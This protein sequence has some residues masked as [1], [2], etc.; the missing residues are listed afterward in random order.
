M[1]GMN[2]R[3]VSQVLLTHLEDHDKLHRRVTEVKETLKNVQMIETFGEIAVEHNLSAPVV[4]TMRA[5]PG[6][7]QTAEQFPSEKLFNVIPEHKSSV[8]QMAALE[9]LGMVQSSNVT[10]LCDRAKAVVSA[11]DS[12]L[13]GLGTVAENYKVQLQEDYS[14]VNAIDLPEDVLTTLPVYTMSEEGFNKLFGMMEHYLK[15]VTVFD[16]EQLQ[17]DPKK[18]RIEIDSLNDIVGDLG[19]A[20]GITAN[21]WGITEKD[22][23]DE[24][25]PTASTFGEKGITKATLCSYIERAQDLCD[26]LKG[27]SARKDDL[28]SGLNQACEEIPENLNSDEVCYGA[29]DHFMLFTGYATLTTKLVR[30]AVVLVSRIL[31]AADSVISLDN[32]KSTEDKAVT[33]SL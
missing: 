4:A 6:F 33:S 29:N 17:T 31:A 22:K 28:I 16:V 10:T 18:I 32:D 8:N 7:I 23:S 26:I 30:E 24:Y 5:V 3:T 21:D 20:L 12:V 13:G 9:S 25:S 2:V 11:M 14:R 15:E 27:I 19:D 1:S